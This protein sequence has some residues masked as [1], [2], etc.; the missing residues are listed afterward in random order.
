MKIYPTYQEVILLVE[1]VD[2]L[3]TQ[4]RKE[5]INL[6]KALGKCRED[7]PDMKRMANDLMALATIRHWLTYTLEQE[8]NRNRSAKEMKGGD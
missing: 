4:R 7:D 1:A 5:R 6:T 2:L 8:E 3:A